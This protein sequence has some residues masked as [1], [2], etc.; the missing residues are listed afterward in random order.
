MIDAQ[1]YAEQA[2]FRACALHVSKN[3]PSAVALYESLGFVQVRE[4]RRFASGCLFR[5][6]DWFLMRKEISS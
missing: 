2:G 4:E 5:E 6:Y 3:N 1:A